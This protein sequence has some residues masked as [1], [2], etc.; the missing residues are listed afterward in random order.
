MT[1]KTRDAAWPAA[2]APGDALL[3]DYTFDPADLPALW[4]VLAP[5]EQ[6]RAARQ[7]DPGA[8]AASIAAHGLKRLLL[9]H[10]CG[11]APAALAFGAAPGGKPYLAAS[12]RWPVLHFSLAHTRGRVALAVM[13]S[14]PV[15]VDVERVR[16]LA[17]ALARHILHPGDDPAPGLL[18]H[19]VAKEAVTKAWGVGL[20][21]PFPRLCPTPGLDGWLVYQDA[22]RVAQVLRGADA[23]AH[24]A[25][26]VDGA[27]CVRL[28]RLVVA[29]P[30]GLYNATVPN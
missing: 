27:A 23:V 29:H 17:P 24:W 7:R 22:G 6:E 11:V 9:A 12:D 4:A 30:P 3:L 18:A 14:H 16:P 19:W 26:A 2:L 8:R 1:T 10:L 15:G 28:R 20:Q 25:V 13:D 5:A 21:L